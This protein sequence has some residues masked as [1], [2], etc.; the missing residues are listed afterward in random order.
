LTILCIDGLDPDKWIDLGLE[1]P[2]ESRLSIP[3]ELY[4]NE[5]PFTPHV[6]PSIFSGKKVRHPDV[7][8]ELNQWRLKIRHWLNRR[9]IKWFRQGTKIK[10]SQSEETLEP[11]WRHWDK[12]EVDTVFDHYPHLKFDIPGVSPGFMFGSEEHNK[13]N[14]QI[15]KTLAI[16][17][18]NSPLPLIALYTHLMD[19]QAHHFRPIDFLYKETKLLAE[20]IQVKREVII[21]SDHGC[22]DGMHTDH[23]YFGSTQPI[24]AENVVQVREDIENI[25]K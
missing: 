1:M 11:T 13:E 19:W 17:T 3:H 2:Y 4:Q 10:S 24:S 8:E 9:G 21:I 23:A 25:L 7:G 12:L 20:T 22:L 16:Q 5:V 18:L 15:Y 6:W 14:H